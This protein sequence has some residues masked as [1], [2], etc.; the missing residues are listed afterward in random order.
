MST[1]DGS[2]RLAEAFVTVRDLC[3]DALR[4]FSERGARLLCGSVAFYALLSIVP[5]LV[6]AVRMASWF[7]DAKDVGSAL[8]HELEYWVG[9]RG[10]QTLL[11]LVFGAPTAK[12]SSLTSALGLLALWY[13]ATRLF[14]L[15]IKALDLLL[16]KEPDRLAERMPRLLRQLRRRGLAF[17]MVLVVGLMLLG[18]VFFH[19]G[20]GWARHQLALEP[21]V[22]RPVEAFVSFAVATSLFSLMFR[23]LP[24][25]SVRTS[26]ALTGGVVTASL[27]TLGSVLITA[28]ITQRDVSVYGAAG[29][30]VTLMLWA[31]Y[32]AHAFFL[33][34]A[35]TAAHAGRRGRLALSAESAKLADGEGPSSRS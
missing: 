17:G 14:S 27:F 9:V 19:V 26:D 15:L 31:H 5:I 32:S 12:G 24:S 6:I 22:S 2:G 21:F 30:L 34:A 3:R 4:I 10:S 18:L 25:A 8:G 35:F 20:L 29:A 7:V 1:R 13:A 16:A 33:G 11:A 23:V 28:Y